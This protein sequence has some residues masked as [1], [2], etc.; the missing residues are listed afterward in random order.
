MPEKDVRINELLDGFEERLRTQ[1]K[2][3]RQQAYNANT[4]GAAYESAFAE[5]L[6]DYFGGIYD[7][8]TRAAVIDHDLRCFEV[9]DNPQQ[10]EIDV[11]AVSKQAKPRFV[12]QANQ[13]QWVPYNGVSFACE[14]KSKLST[15][16]L[17]GDLNKLH[18][19]R[20]L[21]GEEGRQLIPMGFNS[22]LSV[23]HQL[24]CLIYDDSSAVNVDTAAGILRE[25]IE[26]WDL[27]LLVNEDK[28]II[29]PSLPIGQTPL[30]E[31]DVPEDLEP[32]EAALMK[33]DIANQH[34][35]EGLLILEDGFLR[36]IINLSLSIP[37]SPAVETATP[38][39]MMLH[40]RVANK[41]SEQ[42]EN[43]LSHLPDE[44]VETEE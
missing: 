6:K 10:N 29:N 2:F 43:A 13:M 22:D 31:D 15:S 34:S 17:R 3:Y 11:V 40:H 42:I 39:L 23:N 27:V 4:K 36:F 28:L 37:F 8:R 41:R 38:L 33:W 5:L 16:D 21:T 30:D 32:A 14:V 1:W 35:S 7:I 26:D 9:F 18:K 19:L 12:F 44:D 25:H 20:Q 24:L